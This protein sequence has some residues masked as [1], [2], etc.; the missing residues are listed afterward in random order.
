MTFSDLTLTGEQLA[1]ARP[2]Q[3]EG[4]RSLR[5][6]CPFHGSD[7]QRSLRVNLETGRF[8]CFA[9]QAWGYTEEARTRWRKEHSMS[10]RG[11]PWNAG[12]PSANRLR[13]PVRKVEASTTYKLV[14][15][16]DDVDEL[17][18]RY[19]AA[20]PN[21]PGAEYLSLRKIPIHTAQRCGVGYAAPGR[22][23]HPARGWLEGRLVAPHTDQSGRVLN[24]YGRAIELHG[25]APKHL[26][27][28]HLPAA[29][30]RRPVKGV[31]NASAL[32]SARVFIAE[33]PFDALSLLALGLEA[34]AIFGLDGW[35][36]KWVEAKEIV[37]ALDSD[38]A[39]RDAFKRLALEAVIRG[40][41][42]YF[43]PPDTLGDCKDINEA[44]A[45]GLLSI[46]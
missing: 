32:R 4:G 16:R 20:L 46:L 14:P 39:G 37:L 27:H 30:G 26:R 22:W 35:R 9:C 19:Q 2:I 25:E 24:L 38:R 28:D 34:A 5:A 44:F 31:F 36:W 13:V 43:L 12:T 21:S 11:K 6:F 33:G 23:A 1:H 41:Q 40:K 7:R 8:N 29:E 18:H 10:P 42:V 17:L 3:G 15:V 45:K